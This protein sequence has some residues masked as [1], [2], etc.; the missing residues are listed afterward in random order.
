MVYIKE[1]VD[2]LPISCGDKNLSLLTFDNMDWYIKN[3]KKH[4]YEEFLDFKFSSDI[5]DSELREAIYNMI[6]GYKLK[7]SSGYEARL[8]LKGTTDNTVYGGCTIF[9]KNNFKEN[10][11]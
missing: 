11:T 3:C 2:I 6:I 8:L 10:N 9:E 1:L 5:R 4:Y 7:I